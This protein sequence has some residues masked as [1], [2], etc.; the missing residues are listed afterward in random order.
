[1]QKIIIGRTQGD[2]EALDTEEAINKELKKG[3]E[4]VSVYPCPC[5]HPRNAWEGDR[6]VF[7]LEKEKTSKT[8]IQNTD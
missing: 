1:M 7:V 4:L 5:A 6:A 8:T 2:D 3:W